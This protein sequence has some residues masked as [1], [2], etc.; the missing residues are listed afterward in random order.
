M[1]VARILAAERNFLDKH[2]NEA[3]F[4]VETMIAELEP[5]FY[6]PHA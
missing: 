3:V 2:R 1:A 5:V 4:P 6:P